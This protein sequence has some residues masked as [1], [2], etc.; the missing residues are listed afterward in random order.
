MGK[1]KS[2]SPFS[3]WKYSLIISLN[4]MGKKEVSISL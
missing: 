1:K 4:Y 3:T 2:V